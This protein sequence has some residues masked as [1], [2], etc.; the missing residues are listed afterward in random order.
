MPTPSMLDEKLRELALLR[1]N[2]DAS[3]QRLPQ[4]SSRINM[5]VTTS[6]PSFVRN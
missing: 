1:A 5:G 6:N 2:Y 3:A 4:H